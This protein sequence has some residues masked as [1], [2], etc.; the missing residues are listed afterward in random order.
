MLWA[1]S[2]FSLRAV[3]TTREGHPLSVSNAATV[4]VGEVIRWRVAVEGE[5]A[6]T[7]PGAE[8]WFTLLI[9]NRSN[10]VDALSLRLKTDESVDASPWSIA[11]FEQHEDG[12]A[13]A[14]GC[15]WRSPLRR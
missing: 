10:T 13:L 2:T 11:L 8:G 9:Q 12:S 14:T 5:P 1:G 3:A 6:L 15:Y 4:T 7:V